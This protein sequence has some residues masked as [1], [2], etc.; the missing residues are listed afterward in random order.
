M[1]LEK[2]IKLVFIFSACGLISIG[3]FYDDR[4]DFFGLNISIVISFLY[5]VSSILLLFKIR[6]LRFNIPKFILYVFF[7]SLILFTPL[8][9]MHF[10]Y[11]IYGI[12][13]YLSFSLMIVPISIIIIETFNKKDM[14]LMM[15]IL[16]CVSFFLMILGYQDFENAKSLQGQ[17]MA[18]LGGGPIVF[19][20]WLIIGSLI[21]FFHPKVKSVYKFIILPLFI[22]MAFAAG[23]RG[24]MY[25][26]IIIMMFY[27]IVT[28]RKNGIRFLFFTCCALIFIFSI[29]IFDKMEFDTIDIQNRY[30]EL[31]NPAKRMTNPTVGGYARIDRVKRSVNLVV[32]Y[33]LGVGIGNWAQQTNEFSDLSHRDKEYPHNIVLELANETG[34]LVAV[35]FLSLIFTV[36]LLASSEFQKN[37]HYLLRIFFI[38][39]LYMLI[40]TMISGDLTDSRFLFIFLSLY[41]AHSLSIKENKLLNK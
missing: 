37:N 25:S 23:S 30:L 35:I 5:L 40:N 13:K 11:N 9:W 18:V 33:P 31:G 38:L 26:F 27:L 24:P 10:G 21:L 22:F 20:R 8:F 29:K 39:F 41:L 3:Y 1:N 7:G 36:F 19:G 32:R 28:F 2:I 17:R 6:V 16:F 12:Q 15:W 4:L 14:E 34:L